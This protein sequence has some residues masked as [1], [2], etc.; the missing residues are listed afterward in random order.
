MTSQVAPQET[1]RPAA[2]IALSKIVD[3][4]RQKRSEVS[5]LLS[6]V[7]GNRQKRRTQFSSSG[8]PDHETDETREGIEECPVCGVCLLGV[9]TSIFEHVSEC[10]QR[11]LRDERQEEGE[12][13]QVHGH[14][15][16]VDMLEGGILSLPNTV[17]VNGESHE[18]VDVFIDVEGD[19]EEVYGKVQYTED[20]LRNPTKVGK[21]AGI[22]F[23]FSCVEGVQG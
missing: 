16:A 10:L 13:W 19:S 23:P 6:R 3:R 8:F 12:Q 5:S 7:R 15:R 18:E 4:P 2:V 22:L 14:E 17:I 20:D 1:K 9:E 11:R 21:V